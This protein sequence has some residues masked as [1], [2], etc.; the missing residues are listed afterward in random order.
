MD[1]QAQG[2]CFDI[3]VGGVALECF[4]P[5]GCSGGAD[6]FWDM[7]CVWA[8]WCAALFSGPLAAAPCEQALGSQ[9]LPMIAAAA[10]T[11]VSSKQQQAAASW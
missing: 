10:L 5:M 1:L 6:E 4:G 7:S 3:S 8:F 11:K 9:R 2:F